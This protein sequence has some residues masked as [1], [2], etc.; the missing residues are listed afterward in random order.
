MRKCPVQVKRNLGKKA[1]DP[2]L[3]HCYVLP[4]SW[5]LDLLLSNALLLSSAAVGS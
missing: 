2:R 4:V 3:C 1:V 5:N